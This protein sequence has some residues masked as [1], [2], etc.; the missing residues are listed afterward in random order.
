MAVRRP[1]P[2]APNKASRCPLC[3]AVPGEDHTVTSKPPHGPCP[4]FGVDDPAEW[5]VS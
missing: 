1:P 4:N 5:V 2:R 3:N